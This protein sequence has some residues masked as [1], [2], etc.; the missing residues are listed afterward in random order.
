MLAERPNFTASSS[1]WQASS[2]VGASTSIAGGPRSTPFLFC[3]KWNAGSKNPHVLPEP[4]LATVITS[5]P[6]SA[7]G[8]ACACV[9]VGDEKPALSNAFLIGGENGVL[10]KVVIGGGGLSI[11]SIVIWLALQNSIADKP[12]T[13]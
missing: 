12:A 2:L 13:L 10:S 7:I 11:P 5:L 9:G 1:I 3:N 6:A 4:V 8:H